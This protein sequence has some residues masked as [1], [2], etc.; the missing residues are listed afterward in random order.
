M[1]IPVD[2]FGVATLFVAILFAIYFWRKGANEFRDKT[3]LI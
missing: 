3:A 2:E 1:E